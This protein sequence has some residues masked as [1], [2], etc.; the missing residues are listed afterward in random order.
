[1]ARV[2]AMARTG[3]DEDFDRGDNVY[4]HYYGD[5]THKPNPSFGAIDK[6]PY[7]AVRFWPGDLSTKGGLMADKHARVLRPDGSVIE[8]LYVAG[9]NAAPVMGRT[10]PGAG[11]TIGPSMVFAWIA[12]QHAAELAKA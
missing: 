9:N 7:F 6:A 8:G 12:G 11:A 10:Y 5:P 1:M 4:D 2:N 3:V